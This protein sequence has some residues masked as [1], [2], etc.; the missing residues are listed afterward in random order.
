MGLPETAGE[1][2]NHDRELADL[3]RRFM[4]GEFTAMEY[5]REKW[6]LEGTFSEKPVLFAGMADATRGIERPTSL[7]GTEP[8]RDTDGGG[9]LIGGGVHRSSGRDREDTAGT[10]HG[11]FI[12]LGLALLLVALYMGASI[13]VAGPIGFVV[14]LITSLIFGPFLVMFCTIIGGIIDAGA[15]GLERAG[16]SRGW[17]YAGA[18]AAFA[19]VALIWR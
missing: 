2:D 16:M 17:S 1:D 11:T 10:P 18:V 4:R 9:Y 19:L 7:P 6:K 3:Q 14:S 5:E 12:G 8:I 15:S 13:H